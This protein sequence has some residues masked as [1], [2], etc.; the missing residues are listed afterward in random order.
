MF[1]TVAMS[2]MIGAIAISSAFADENCLN[3]QAMGEAALK[4]QNL[5]VRTD[6]IDVQGLEKAPHST[7]YV[8]MILRDSQ[9]P[10]INNYF[11]S[12]KNDPTHK[13]IPDQGGCA[14][15]SVVR[16]PE[17]AHYQY[18][19]IVEATQE[20]LTLRSARDGSVTVFRKVGDQRL[21]IVAEASDLEQNETCNPNKV[22]N[23]FTYMG[24][25]SWGE[26]GSLTATSP[27]EH[28]LELLA[29]YGTADSLTECMPGKAK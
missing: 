10:D 24:D 18:F 16:I 15:G 9:N 13:R 8:G 21:R 27:S 22:S 11:F 28:L 25:I 3:L 4:I 14:P 23:T 2:F 17:S 12:F 7:G 19:T 29:R 1:K 5:E 26:T 20:S 6:T